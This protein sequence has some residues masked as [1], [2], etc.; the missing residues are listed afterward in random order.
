ME[1]QDPMKRDTL[2]SY[3]QYCD[4]LR[5]TNSEGIL[6][7]EDNTVDISAQPQEI[8]DNKAKYN[9]YRRQ[10]VRKQVNYL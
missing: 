5:Q 1:P 4:W 9:E 7:T 6:P 2:M 8:P 10:F 3:K